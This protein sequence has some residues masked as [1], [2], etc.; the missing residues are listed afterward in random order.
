MPHNYYYENYSVILKYI[1]IGKFLQVP[2]MI[3]CRYAVLLMGQFL[4]IL[5]MFEMFVEN[6]IVNYVH[7]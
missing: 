3:P 4:K 1:V 7:L 5:S 6:M 2:V